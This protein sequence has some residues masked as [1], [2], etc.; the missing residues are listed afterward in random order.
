MS[1]QSRRYAGDSESLDVNLTPMIDV[2]FLLISFFMIVSQM[3]S[4]EV[5][6]LY[7]P[8]ADAVIPDKSED[9][10]RFILNVTR[11]GDILLRGE[12]LTPE[13]MQKRL[14]R[15]ADKSRTG[16]SRFSNRKILVRADRDAIYDFIQLVMIKCTEVGIFQIQFGAKEVKKD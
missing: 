15:E 5:S 8:S 6:V 7:L 11:E 3:V 2:V 13:L 16:G 4:N 14:K 1:K 9:P 10:D 12:R